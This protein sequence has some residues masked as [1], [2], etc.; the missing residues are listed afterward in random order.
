MRNVANAVEEASVRLHLVSTAPRLYARRVSASSNRARD[1][2]IY[3]AAAALSAVATA[4]NA[5]AVRVLPL[6]SP[7]DSIESY[8]LRVANDQAVPIRSVE[9]RFPTSVK[10][11]S[12]GARP[13]WPAEARLADSRITSVVW[14]GVLDPGRFTDF[15]FIARNPRTTVRLFWPVTVTLVDGQSIS[16]WTDQRSPTKA[17]VTVV[18]SPPARRD[19]RLAMIVCLVALVLA[20]IALVLAIRIR[21]PN[22]AGFQPG[23][24]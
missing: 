23:A 17:P 24:E 18:T 12:L 13:D 3:I 7:V 15:A 22:T 8:V 20:L 10:V 21:P 2:L 1:L 9:L 16:W 5:Q 4:A 14:T 6:S 11:V 19:L